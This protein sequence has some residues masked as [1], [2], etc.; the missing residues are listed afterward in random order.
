MAL[1][2]GFVLRNRYHDRFRCG[3]IDPGPLLIAFNLMGYDCLLERLIDDLPGVVRVVSQIVDYQCAL[4]GMWAKAGAHMVCVIDEFAG[5]QGMMFSPLLWREHVKPLYR[6]LFATIRSL[7]LYAGV[8]FDGDITA[9]LDD[10]PDLGID[11]LDIR[12]PNSVGIEVYRERFA[13][14][15]AMKASV[16]MMTTLATGA[17]DEARAE[18]ERL[19]REL[20]T[21]RGGFMGIVLRWHRPEYPAANVAASVEGFRT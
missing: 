4:A 16:D 17:P 8:L 21:P 11:V 6:R 18:A 15:L 14:R 5:T 19:C 12:Q 10:I 3:Y 13:G 7:G 2:P 20:S 9:I 1:K